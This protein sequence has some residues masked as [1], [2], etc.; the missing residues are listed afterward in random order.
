MKT[1]CIILL[2][3][4]LPLIGIGQRA[5]EV[6]QWGGMKSIKGPRAKSAL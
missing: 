1:S 2:L 3:L 5:N 6:F 4:C